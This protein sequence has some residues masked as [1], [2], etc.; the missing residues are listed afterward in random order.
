MLPRRI[1]KNFGKILKCNQRR[2]NFAKIRVGDHN[3]KKFEKGEFYV[4]AHS[5]TTHPDAINGVNLALIKIDS[6]KVN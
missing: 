1:P 2:E 6:L 4:Q 5:W 3:Q